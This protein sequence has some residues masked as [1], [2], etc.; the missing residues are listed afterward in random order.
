MY[1]K[2]DLIAKR[3]E[4]VFVSSA[5]VSS[6]D[7]SS[8]WV[9]FQ[10]KY[11]EMFTI[12]FT[13]KAKIYQGNPAFF[14]FFY[15]DKIPKKFSSK[16]EVL[17]EIIHSSFVLD[18]GKE[19]SRVENK[20]YL[21]DKSFLLDTFVEVPVGLSVITLEERKRAFQRPTEVYVPKNLKS[22]WG[23]LCLQRFYVDEE[24]F[25]V[26]SDFQINPEAAKKFI[27]DGV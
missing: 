24:L 5:L 4:G 12:I 1:E 26:K 17:T 7:E 8:S 2:L 10:Q 15:A 16:Q 21:R 13:D 9:K 25:K 27:L 23:R 19:S 18:I 14:R 3:T 6:K 20:I 11:P 22:K